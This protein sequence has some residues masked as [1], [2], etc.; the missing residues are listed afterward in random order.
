MNGS[1]LH[2]L[3]Q[4]AKKNRENRGW[5]NQDLYRLLYKEDIYIAAYEKIKSNKG[6]LT[7]GSTSETL[8][9]FSAIKIQDIIE[10][11]KQNRFVFK[12]ARRVL[13]PKHGRKSFRPLGLFTA[14]DKVVQEA[15]RMI[16]EAI[17]EPLFSENSHGFRPKRSCHTALRQ[18]DREFDGMKWLL[19]GD[20]QTAYATVNHGVLLQFLRRSIRDERFI[21]FINKALKAGYAEKGPVPIVSLVGTP[22]GSILSPL[23]FNIYLTPFDHF[24]EKLKEKYEK[25]NA[26]KKRSSTT[27]YNSN[28]TQMAQTRREIEGCSDPL[29][30]KTLKNKLRRLKQQRVQIQP[31]RDESI[32]IR[33]RYVRYADDWVIG[34]NGPRKLAEQLKSD[35]AHFLKG[36][37]FLGLSAEKTKI[38]YLKKDIGTFLGYQIRVES[39]EKVTKIRNKNNVTFTKRTTGHFVKLDAPIQKIIANLCLKGF[40]DAKG[41]PLSKRSWTTFDDHVI[42]Q[43]YNHILHGLFQYYSGADNQRKLIRI[44]FILQHSCGCTLAHRHSCSVA[45]IY[46]KHSETMTITYRIVKKNG[47]EEKKIALSLRKFNKSEQRWLISKETFHDPFQV[48]AYRR[49]RS[50]LYQC[51]CICGADQ[52]VEVHH[53]RRI[54][55]SIETKGFQEILGIL[56]RK[57]I[58]VCRDCHRSIHMGKYD[59]LSVNDLALPE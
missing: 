34:V 40:C 17:Y 14:S 8:D 24:L 18:I 52:H 9:G 56:N 28:A 16:L 30:R 4:I 25:G 54:R 31:Y 37:L 44:Q 46:A 51:C 35:V 6:A 42:I 58:P 33:I 13:I 38:T 10:R 21:Q 32:P 55:G 50:K 7:K 3:E 23:L 36:E 26:E 20:I 49:T 57:Q 1:A 27:K 39:S 5:I 2:R 59:G 29:A 43:Q 12:P 48:Y 22:Q 47:P 45:K 11:M 41:R 19:E 53:I 15:V